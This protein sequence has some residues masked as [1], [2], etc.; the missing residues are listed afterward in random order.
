MN[1]FRGRINRTTFLLGNVLFIGIAFLL[2]HSAIIDYLDAHQSNWGLMVV[3]AVV[4]AAPLIFILSVGIRRLHDLSLPGW[5][6][7]ITILPVVDLVLL[8]LKGTQG[9]NKYGQAPKV[10]FDFRT[11]FSL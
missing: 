2:S 5:L 11:L 7:P 6:W 10:H 9:E 8:I 1:I 4:F 3:T